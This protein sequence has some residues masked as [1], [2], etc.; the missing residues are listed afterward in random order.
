MHWKIQYQG[1]KYC[2]KIKAYWEELANKGIQSD[3]CCTFQVNL[4]KD[5][6]DKFYDDEDDH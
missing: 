3:L 5:I 4:S 6:V 2:P 1:A